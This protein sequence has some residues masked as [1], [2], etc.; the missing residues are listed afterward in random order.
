MPSVR[1]DFRSVSYFLKSWTE[2]PH[3]F[4]MP[5]SRT[6][7][8]Y[9]ISVLIG[10]NGPTMNFETP[11]TLATLVVYGPTES[12]ILPH[13]PVRLLPLPKPHPLFHYVGGIF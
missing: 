4:A 6:L 2:R 9:Q 5:L 13:L 8:L 11:T 3:L 7:L 10:F 1:H 12:G